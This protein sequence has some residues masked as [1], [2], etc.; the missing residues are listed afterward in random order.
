[1]RA[2]N[3]WVQGF[4]LF[5]NAAGGPRGDAEDQH[6]AGEHVITPERRSTAAR[7]LTVLCCWLSWVRPQPRTWAADRQ[8][9]RYFN[10]SWALWACWCW[11]PSLNYHCSRHCTFSL[12]FTVASLPLYNIVGVVVTGKKESTDGDLA[13]SPEEHRSSVSGWR[14]G[15]LSPTDLTKEV[16]VHFST[17]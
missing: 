7:S 13:R 10:Q 16:N 6:A 2:S 9:T 1:M 3:D 14:T 11:N 8:Q 4:A 15:A 17:F 5:C 12:A